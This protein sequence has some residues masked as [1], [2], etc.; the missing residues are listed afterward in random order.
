[1]VNTRSMMK[2]LSRPSFYSLDV[3]SG[4][5]NLFI[6][7]SRNSRGLPTR[8]VIDF[9]KRQKSSKAS[10][11]FRQSVLKRR[12]LPGQYWRNSTP[13]Q[14]SSLWNGPRSPSRG[15]SLWSAHAPSARSSIDMPEPAT[16]LCLA[17]GPPGLRPGGQPLAYQPASMVWW[18]RAFRGLG[19]QVERE[20]QQ[21]LAL[22]LGMLEQF[23]RWDGGD[24]AQLLREIPEM[25]AGM[26]RV[27]GQVEALADW[28]RRL[29]R[30][31]EE[32]VAEPEKDS[33]SKSSDA[34]VAVRLR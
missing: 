29:G 12:S 21:M 19:G 31:F 13:S 30:I 22:E 17:G 15:S 28:L 10:H 24:R 3:S 16:A 26:D 2:R 8:E 23:R 34:A 27:Q 14:G 7:E 11:R 4:S 25:A 32:D 1:M 5:Y 6:R 33:A 20:V 18:L 9:R